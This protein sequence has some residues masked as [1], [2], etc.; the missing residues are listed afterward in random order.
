ML[1]PTLPCS[2]SSTWTWIASI[3]IIDDFHLGLPCPHSYIHISYTFQIDIQRALHIPLSKL[4]S[5]LSNVVTWHFFYYSLFNV[6]PFFHKVV[7][8]ATKKFAVVYINTWVAL[9]ENHT[10]KT[11]ALAFCKCLQLIPNQTPPPSALLCCAWALAHFGKYV[12]T[13]HTLIPSTPT[14]VDLASFVDDF[15]LETEVTLNQEAFVSTLA[16]SPPLSSNGP[17]GMV[18]ELLQN[19]FVLDDF[20]N[21]FDLF[22]EVCKHLLEVMFHP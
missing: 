16:C 1:P 3:N 6:C 21:G 7:K 8:K 2:P 9:Q 4:A 17:S 18:Y 20:V 11:F 14:E 5:D 12:R 13:I 22:F 15:H 19:C 10:I